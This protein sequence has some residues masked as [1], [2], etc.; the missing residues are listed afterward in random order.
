MSPRN[1]HNDEILQRL[2][3]IETMIEEVVRQ[4][5]GRVSKL[6]HANTRIVAMAAVIGAV[7]TAAGG[8]VAK[9]GGIAGLIGK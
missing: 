6:E 7:M 1:P 4:L 2:T 8:W 9:V 3:R 5:P